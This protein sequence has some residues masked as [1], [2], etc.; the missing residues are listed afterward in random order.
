MPII[1]TTPRAAGAATGLKMFLYW[2]VLTL[3]TRVSVWKA[4]RVAS[5]A[6]HVLQDYGGEGLQ[7]KTVIAP[8]GA[9]QPVA[10]GTKNPNLVLAIGDFYAQKNYPLLMEAFARLLKERPDTR[11]EIIGRKVDGAE[12]VRVET[13]MVRW[14]I[15]RAVTLAGGM[16]HAALLKRLAE[17]AV[18]VNV[19]KAECFNMPLLEAMAVGTPVVCGDVDFQREVVGEAGVGQAAVLVKMDDGQV[20]DAVAVA[21]FG[22]LETPAIASQLRTA[23]LRR[24]AVFTWEQTAG[25]LLAALAG[26]SA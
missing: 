5:V 16:P 7:R 25:A 21:V 18:L 14:G 8:P 22:V 9:P 11:L 15:S 12:V 13:E 17:A 4:K 19:S 20:A 26:P 10:A 24:A 2:R 3:L 6:R 1:H 23:G